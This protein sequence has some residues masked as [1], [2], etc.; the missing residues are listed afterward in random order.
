MVLNDLTQLKEKLM[1]VEKIGDV[2]DFFFDHF[3]EDPQFMALGKSRKPPLLRSILAKLAKE[4]Y[5]PG[6]KL[7][8]LRLKTLR[9][10]RFAHGACSLGGHP[11]SVLYF[12]D[13][14]LGS[15]AATDPRSGRTH[16]VRFTEMGTAPAADGGSA[17]S[18]PLPP[19][20]REIN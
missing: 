11:A 5:G 18:M 4:L 3:G 16:F 19:G 2:W 6:A 20:A 17:A 10:Q 8:G 9:A 15:V 1:T 12:A 7:T 14:G 13:I